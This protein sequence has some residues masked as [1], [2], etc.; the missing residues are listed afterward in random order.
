M[1]TRMKSMDVDRYRYNC[2]GLC[3]N[4][5]YLKSI[6]RGRMTITKG[7]HANFLE[8]SPFYYLSHVKKSIL[9]IHSSRNF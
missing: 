6:K 7:T 5:I 2:K 1:V 8:N 4:F 9:E 3:E